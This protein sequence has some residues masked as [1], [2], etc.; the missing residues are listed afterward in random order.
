VVSAVRL[1]RLGIASSVR[2]RQHSTRPAACSAAAHRRC[3]PAECPDRASRHRRTAARR[4]SGLA[5]ATRSP[6]QPMNWKGVDIFQAKTIRGTTKIAAE[7]RYRVEV[8]L[9]RR[10]ERL[11]TV[12]SSIMRRRRG[13]ISAIGTSCLKG[14]VAKNPQSFQTGGDY[15]DCPLTAAPTLP[16]SSDRL[17]SAFFTGD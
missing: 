16:F 15:R 13:L 11:R 6:S 12:M 3:A 5:Q 8:R 4:R 14:W 9:L 1:L 17:Q 7:L 10:G 2:P